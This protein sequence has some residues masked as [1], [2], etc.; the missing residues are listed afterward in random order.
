MASPSKPRQRRRGAID[1]LPSGSLRVRV[2]GGV[3]LVSG[4]RHDLVE[5]VPAGPKAAAEAEKVRTRLLLR[6]V[7]EKRNSRIR[8]TVN[9]LLDRY[10]T[11]LKVE[12]TTREGYESIIRTHI[13]PLLGELPLSRIDG[14]VTRAGADGGPMT[15]PLSAD[16]GD[17]C[18]CDGR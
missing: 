9:Q 10:L 4:M 17:I 1:V 11:L 3:D 13:C 15:G 5:I 2:F 8:A 12:A 14:E 16:R 18:R 6:Q 7:D